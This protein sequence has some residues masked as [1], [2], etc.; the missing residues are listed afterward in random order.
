MK[1]IAAAMTI[2]AVIAA[3]LCLGRVVIAAD[4]GA[5]QGQVKPAA[6]ADE[7]ARALAF[8]CGQAVPRNL[9]E[10]ARQFRRAAEQGHVEAQGALGWMLM[11]GRGVERNE[12]EA[13]LWL[14]RAAAQGNV[15]A[16]NNLGV[17]Y[18][19]GHGL[20]HDHREAERWF[21][22]AADQGALDAQRNLDEMLRLGPQVV[23]PAQSVPA[24]L[25]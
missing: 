1:S 18:A 7:Y 10:A 15:P 9:A 16:Q 8:A 14:A 21:R 13:A 11:T 19:L 22:A 6:G 3:P 25:Y 2:I 5:A 17:L 12:S 20:P 24:P 23:R 4:R